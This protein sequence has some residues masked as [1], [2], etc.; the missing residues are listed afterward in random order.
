[1]RLTADVDEALWEPAS[2]SGGFRERRRLKAAVRMI[3][4]RTQRQLGLDQRVGRVGAWAIS[5][6]APALLRRSDGAM[7]A[8]VW[9]ED[10]RL[11]VVMAQ[12]IEMT[13]QARAARAMA[14]MEY[15]DT[16][17]FRSQH[18]G[19]GERLV[20][21]LPSDP[22]EEPSAT[23]TWD[24]GTHLVTLSALCS[25]RARFG[26]VLTPLDELARSLRFAGDEPEDVLR[27]PPA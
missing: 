11:V 27:I 8:W 1:M 22:R 20:R 13:A 17:D 2:A 25:D 23:Y 16:E 12:A 3:V 10:P 18:L 26:T 6:A 4:S 19:Q 5:Q 7:L 9:R 21:D 24:T 15:D 14:P